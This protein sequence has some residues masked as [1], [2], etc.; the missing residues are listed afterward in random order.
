MDEAYRFANDNHFDYFTTVMT[1]SRQK[2]S[3]KINEIGLA[4]STKYQTKYFASDFKKKKGIDRA[5]EL[6]KEYN[7]YNQ[8]YC[9]CKFSYEKYLKKIE[10][11]E[12][13]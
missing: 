9:G 1:I 3:Q 6:R 7:L 8:Q 11:G 5:V 12:E 2:N 13:N 4:L 10:S